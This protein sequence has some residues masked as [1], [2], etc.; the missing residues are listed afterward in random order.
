MNT[1]LVS[2]V[3]PIHNVER[4]LRESVDSV[5]RQTYRNL[6]IILVDDESPDN[7]PAICDEYAKKDSRVQVIHKPNGGLS[8]AR[9]WGFE[10]ARGE[11]VYF[12]DS[13]DYIEDT[14]VHECLEAIEKEAAD[15]VYF[16]A[17]VFFE[18]ES[19]ERDFLSWFVRDQKY[20]TDKGYKVLSQM[21]DN[22]C[23]TAPVWMYFI[24]TEFLRKHGFTFYKGILYEDLLYTS[25]LYLS[26]EKIAHL[27]KPL[28]FQRQRSDSITGTVKTAEHFRGYAVGFREI[29]KLYQNG[30][31]LPD[32][33]RVIRKLLIYMFITAMRCYSK[34]SA[35]ERK[36]TSVYKTELTQTIRAARFLGNFSVFLNSA[37]FVCYWIMKFEVEIN[38]VKRLFK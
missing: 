38:K 34:L 33:R 25:L 18:N 35:G 22:R 26:A 13:D 8:D 16:D 19:G 15:F 21:L 17:L 3:I 32:I 5:L 28:C 4:Y 2:V 24:K 30:E 6:E 14:L 27:Y 37:K 20:E 12:F 31:I 9:N 10:I 1:P 7:C 23:Y 11:Y 36:K 29:M